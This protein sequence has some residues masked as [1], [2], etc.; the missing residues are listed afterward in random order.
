MA[1]KITSDCILCGAC[2]PACPV[3]CIS[4]GGNIYVVDE[5]EC[6]SCGVCGG[7]CPTGA[8]VEA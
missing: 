4:L 1:Y 3:T 7:I 2:E 5:N 8:A 6:I